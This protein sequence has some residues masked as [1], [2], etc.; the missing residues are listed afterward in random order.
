MLR[1]F[2]QKSS[3]HCVS[4]SGCAIDRFTSTNLKFNFTSCKKHPVKILN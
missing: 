2:L 3:N 1:S 4:Q